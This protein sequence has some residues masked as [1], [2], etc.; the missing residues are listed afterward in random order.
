MASCPMAM[1]NELDGYISIMFAVTCKGMLPDVLLNK[2]DT[3]VGTK[4]NIA[5][6]GDDLISESCRADSTSNDE[7]HALLRVVLNLVEDG[8]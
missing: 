3:Y 7:I 2:R 1:N 4:G 6:D 5:E 8:E